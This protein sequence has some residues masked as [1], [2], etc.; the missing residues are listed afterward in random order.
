MMNSGEAR[1]DTS[2]PDRDRKRL[3]AEIVF[4]GID[5]IPKMQRFVFDEV[6]R[7][8]RI[9]GRMQAWHIV[10]EA[11]ERRHPHTGPLF[12]VTIQVALP[13]NAKIVVQEHPT[14][15]EAHDDPYKSIS[16]AFDDLR[17]RLQ[18]STP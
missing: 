16:D 4:Q 8:E 2:Q 10:L 13:S 14:E 12:N 11:P 5:P 3:N 1:K 9:F 7:L 17:N 18:A 6:E 15:L